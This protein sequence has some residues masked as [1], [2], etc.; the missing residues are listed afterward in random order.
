MRRK[1]SRDSDGLGEPE[2]GGTRGGREE[3]G[4][5]GSGGK[6]AA[7][8]RIR[9]RRQLSKG[10]PRS[11]VAKYLQKRGI[12]VGKL[13]GSRQLECEIWQELDRSTSK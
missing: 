4:G 9:S 5:R 12:E 1:K 8:A 10:R 13:V 2:F 3:H 7:D 6:A 11:R